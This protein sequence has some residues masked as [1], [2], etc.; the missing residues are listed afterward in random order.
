MPGWIWKNRILI[1]ANLT[2]VSMG[3][4]MMA[5]S[6]YL[7]VYAQ[8]VTGVGPIAAGFIL[9]SMSITWPLS[10]AL[11]GR[12]YLKIGFRNTALA[13]A[14][15]AIVGAGAFLFLTFPGPVWAL[16]ATQLLLGAGFGLISTPMIVGVQSMVTWDKRGVVTGANMFSR[17]LD[18]LSVP[19]FSQPYSIQFYF[20]LC[21]KHLLPFNPICRR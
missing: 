2:V 13:G 5:P 17:Y 6:M 11:S 16:V 10:S 12:L 18:K 7:P 8:S 21:I 9:A 4:T 3:A 14:C 20:P 19:Q 15:I 1:G